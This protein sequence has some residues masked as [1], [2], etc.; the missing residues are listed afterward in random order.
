MRQVMWQAYPVSGKKLR[1]KERQRR[2]ICAGKRQDSRAE[3]GEKEG[4]SPL[5]GGGSGPCGAFGTGIAY[6]NR[7]EYKTQKECLS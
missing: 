3:W 4:R 1:N 2:L 7:R 5:W 6:E